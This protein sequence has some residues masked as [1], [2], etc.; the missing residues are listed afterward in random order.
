MKIC[1]ILLALSLLLVLAV[2]VYA[3]LPFTPHAFF[4]NVTL[5]GAPAPIGAI[6]VAKISGVDRGYIVVTETGKYGS[7]SPLAPKLIVQGQILGSTIEFFVNDVRA[8]QA[9]PFNSGETTELDLTAGALPTP[10]PITTPAPA[11]PDPGTIILMG[12]VLLAVAAY[13]VIKTAITRR[14]RKG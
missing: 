14:T 12:S 3:Q 7:L 9:Y 2:P 13:V 11:L 5:N 10:T 1:A 4:G 8:D 6:V